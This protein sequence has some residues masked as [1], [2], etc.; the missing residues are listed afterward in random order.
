MR[1]VNEIEAMHFAFER[2][3]GRTYGLSANHPEY[4]VGYSS[5]IHK[6]D[7]PQ[8]WYCRQGRYRHD[9]GEN[10][11]DCT[12]GT[13]VI[14]PP[15]VLHNVLFTDSAAELV[16]LDLNYTMFLEVAPSQWRN[17]IFNMCMSAFAKELEYEPKLF[18]ELSADSREKAEDIFSFLSMAMYSPLE[19]YNGKRI[20]EKVEELFTLPE[21]I[22]PGTDWDKV[23]NLVQ[24]RLY[25]VLRLVSYLNIHYSEK[26]D[27]ERL[28]QEGGISRTGMYRYFSRVIGCTYSKYLQQMRIH[29][30]LLA[31]R[32]TTFSLSHIADLCGFCDTR[33]MSQVF[34]NYYGMTPKKVR[35]RIREQ[36]SKGCSIP[37]PARHK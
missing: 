5:G 19:T 30:V 27:D 4:E 12:P 31:L 2:R 36:C 33:H 37:H 3:G 32:T 28:L 13:L 35:S 8:I 17:T 21:F 22:Y 1:V 18:V 24:T 29:R 9:V 26:I 10:T 6:H 20:F 7:F 23:L 25:P 34:S 16:M 15:G 11:Y 14:V